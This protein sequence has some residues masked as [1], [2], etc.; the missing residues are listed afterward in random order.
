MH[1]ENCTVRSNN[2][3]YNS[4]FPINVYHT[5]AP[6]A[7]QPSSL[8]LE[9]GV[10]R[11]G[12]SQQPELAKKV[13]AKEQALQSV[14]LAVLGYSSNVV[15]RV[16]PQTTDKRTFLWQ[17]CDDNCDINSE[18]DKTPSSKIVHVVIQAPSS[19][20]ASHPSPARVSEKNR[21]LLKKSVMVPFSKRD[22][23]D[24]YTLNMESDL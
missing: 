14:L 2:D 21:Q 11:R 9:I 17:K 1:K 22:S 6:S 20:N 23:N 4:G 15:S 19:M 3:I 7:L 12:S 24:T 18:A 5:K 13:L 16:E 10:W 8:D